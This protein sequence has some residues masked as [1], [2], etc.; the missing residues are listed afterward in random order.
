MSFKNTKASTLK[1]INLINGKIPRLISINEKNFIKN[2]KKIHNRILKNFK[3]KVAIRSSHYQEDQNKNSYAGY[4]D[5]FLNV[6]KDNKKELRDKILK[7]FKSYKKLSNRNNQNE[8][9]I[10]DMVKD[11]CLSGVVTS[12]DKDNFTPYYI[13]NFTKSSNTADITSGSLNGSTF[14]YYKKSK[15]KPKN[16]YL[17]KVINLVDELIKKKGEALDIEFAFNKKKEIFLLQVR[18]IVKNNNYKNV[19]LDFTNPFKK[20][21]KKIKKL[22]QRHYGLYG[23]TNLFGVMPDWN[24]AE[25]IGI[26]P[27]NL[28]ISL[29]GKL[30]TDEIWAEDRKKFGFKDVTSHHL[31]TNFFGTPYVDIRVDF[32]S[33]IAN[34]LNKKLSE[35]LVNFYLKK[36]KNRT[37]YHDK[38]E[39]NIIFTC[40]TFSTKKKIQELL[41]HGFNK[42]DIFEISKSLKE[43]TKKSFSILKE[44]ILEVNKL[45]ESQE[46]IIN[47]KIYEIDKIYWLIEDCKKFGTSSFASIARCAFIANDFLNS[48]VEL[49]I[50][51]KD[52]RMKFLSSIKT[53]VSEMNEDLFRVSK[54][55]FI[56]KYGHLRPSTYD[57]SSL[58]YKE[59]FKKYFSGKTNF[60]K[61]EKKFFLNKEQ[62]TKIGVLLKKENLE[63]SVKE[64][65][66]FLKL[67][68]SQREKTK[69][70]FSKNIDLV[71]QMILKIGKR[72]NIAREDLG[73]ININTILDL[74]Y[75]LDL[76]NLERKLKA[77]IKYNK[78]NYK[79]NRLIKLPKNIISEKDVNFFLEK[80]PKSNFIARGDVTANIVCLN[81]SLNQNL[82][83]KI[84][85]IESADPGYDFIFSKNIKGLVTMFGGVNSHMAIR[86]SEL[87]IPA[88]IGVGNNIFKNII[89]SKIL[90]LN[91]KIERIDIIS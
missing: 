88:A 87:N 65:L 11:V 84:I 27:N 76:S 39:F 69:F 18:N 16:Q 7:V 55:R 78:K 10:Q 40:F 47:S 19:N 3:D 17:I 4:F 59:G 2:E 49:K 57:I 58:S 91:T 45:K 24:P 38:I 82:N 42:K 44:S 52:D 80:Y 34:K 85:C 9:I 77:E 31:L 25:I 56:K 43:I 67:A 5:S 71:F 50:F 83:G 81:K 75:N 36:Y 64:F 12:C 72:N 1:S 22:K 68:I 14:T 8:V 54:K 86:C 66:K 6:E 74:Y 37:E 41:K 61:T 60:K 28:A 26:R 35:K 79:F 13:I 63:V 33:W 21:S 51:S 46:D 30:I 90:R 73:F 53:V 15:I 70:Y 48:L 29:Y 32:N 20:L 89:S 62:N 23:N